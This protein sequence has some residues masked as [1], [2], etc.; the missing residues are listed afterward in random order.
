MKFPSLFIKRRSAK[1]ALKRSRQNETPRVTILKESPAESF[2][3]IFVLESFFLRKLI[4]TLTPGEN[5]EMNFLTGPKIGPIRVVCR[6]AD[7]VSLDGQSPVSAKASAKSVADILIPI[8]EQGA[9][10]HIIAHSH[11]GYGM[12]ATTPSDIDTECLGRLQK[13]GS[14]VIGC[15]VT[16]DACVRFF[17]VSTQFQVLVLG[18]GVNQLSQNV[19]QITYEDCH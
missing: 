5:E 6:M 14:Q 11:P 17:T 15:I 8:I 3:Q 7:P 1:A 18:A 4:T 10:L 2:P 19:F 12:G 9:E 16:R 13:C